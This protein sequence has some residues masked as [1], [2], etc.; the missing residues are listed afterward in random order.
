METLI[1]T[2]SHV[3]ARVKFARDALDL[4]QDQVKVALGFKNRQ[5][6]SDIENGKRAVKA[7]ELLKLSDLL[8]RD[9]EFFVDPFS[10]VGEAEYSWRASPEL[11]EAELDRFQEQASAWVG[12]LRW[13]REQGPVAHSPLKFSLRLDS[14]SSTFESAQRSAEQLVLQLGLQGRPATS[15]VANHT[16]LVANDRVTLSIPNENSAPHIKFSRPSQD[17]MFSYSQQTRQSRTPTL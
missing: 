14:S 10:V 5:T 12:L 2:P 13:L 7:E 17:P 11:A 6:V 16:L 8:D 4:N 1:T 3:G 9:V 15:P